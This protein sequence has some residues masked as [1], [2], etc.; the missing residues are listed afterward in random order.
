MPSFSSAVQSPWDPLAETSK[1]FE[2]KPFDGPDSV[3]VM[4][5]VEFTTELILDGSDKN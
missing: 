1:S 2:H 3:L 4:D 5:P